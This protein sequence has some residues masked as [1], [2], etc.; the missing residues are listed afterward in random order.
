MR[1]VAVV[2]R[3]GGV[4]RGWD[5]VAEDAA[6]GS[7]VRAV[8]DL[9]LEVVDP[10]AVPHAAEHWVHEPGMVVELEVGLLLHLGQGDVLQGYEE[11]GVLDEV[12]RFDREGVGARR[13][14]LKVDELDI[15]DLLLAG[16]GV[17]RRRGVMQ[18]QTLVGE[19][20]GV[21]RRIEQG[22]VDA[23][24]VA[25]LGSCVAESAGRDSAAVDH[26]VA[27]LDVR[28]PRAG[29]AVGGDRVLVVG[30]NHLFDEDSIEI[31]AIRES[32]VAIVEADELLVLL[33]LLVRQLAPEEP[34]FAR[35]GL[36]PAEIG[37]AREPTGISGHM[38]T[39]E[40][41]RADRVLVQLHPR[42]LQVLLPVVVDPV[43]HEELLEIC[44]VPARSMHANDQ[45]IADFEL[46]ALFKLYSEFDEIR[47]DVAAQLYIVSLF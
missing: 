43:R 42:I 37:L 24:V 4:L 7:E 26:V 2:P 13:R 39:E 12:V 15:L 5:V 32:L 18:R 23:R 14:L 36:V 1:V 30:E 22:G 17:R 6:L 40:R 31:E 47:Y 44:G 21:P 11:A 19:L 33:A 41:H 8:L 25:A 45:I 29:A 46:F 16:E 20:K 10:C 35:V 3:A 9:D 28:V 27:D 34:P 38:E